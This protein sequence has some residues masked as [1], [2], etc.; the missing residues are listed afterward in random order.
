MCVYVCVCACVY[1]FMCVCVFVCVCVCVCVC[2]VGL[3]VCWITIMNR[4]SVEKEIKN[5]TMKERKKVNARKRKNVFA[6]VSPFVCVCV[7][8]CVCVFLIFFF[9]FVI[10]TPPVYHSSP[11]LFLFPSFDPPLQSRT[12]HIVLTTKFT[13]LCFFHFY[14]KKR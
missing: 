14:F 9:F 11:F 7:C 8:V 5:E 3:T 6:F 10:I 2:V 1:L 12:I 4:G 13:L